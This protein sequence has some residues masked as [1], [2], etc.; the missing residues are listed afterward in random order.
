MPMN[1]WSLLQPSNP[2]CRIG[3]D[4]HVCVCV[5]QGL[6]PSTTAQ[7]TAA[8]GGVVVMVCVTHSSGRTATT[9]P[10][11]VRVQILWAIAVA[12]ANCPKLAAM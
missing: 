5:I 6:R 3:A 12:Q 1:T 7:L 10:R 2:T 8:T 11:T 4:M 9:V